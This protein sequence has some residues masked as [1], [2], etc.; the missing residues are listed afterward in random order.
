MTIML[1]LSARR[2]SLGRYENGP[3]TPPG[4]YKIRLTINNEVLEQGRL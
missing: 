3:F 2:M 1:H 4:I